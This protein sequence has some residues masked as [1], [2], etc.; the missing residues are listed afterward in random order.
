MVIDKSLGGITMHLPIGLLRI[1]ED[2]DG[3]LVEQG[4]DQVNIYSP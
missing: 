2:G 1:M 3:R 4:C